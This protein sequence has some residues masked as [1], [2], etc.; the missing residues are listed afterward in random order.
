MTKNP[1][2]PI[3]ILTL[4]FVLALT[5][6]AM[7]QEIK[8]G[9]AGSL[10]GDKASYGISSLR[11][12]EYIADL[13]NAQGGLPKIGTIRVIPADEQCDPALAPAAA[14]R[15]VDDGVRLVMGHICSG[16]TWAALDIYNEADA[17]VIS[18]SATNPPLTQ[19]RK[20]PNFFRTIS[21]DDAQAR[22]EVDFAKKNGWMKLAVLHDGG[23]YGKGLAE[24][25]QQFVMA[26]KEMELVSFMAVPEGIPDYANVARI[27]G[28]SG[29]QA[30]IYGGYHPEAAR[31][32]TALRK[33]RV[34]IP[35]ISDD[36][37]KDETFVRTAGT[38]AEGVYATAPLDVSRHPLAIEAVRAHKLKYGD[39]P[40]AFYLTGAAASRA[41]L[42]AVN[43]AG[44]DRNLSKMAE[45]LRGEWV[46]TELGPIKF[47]ARGDAI[48]VGFAVYQVREGRYVEWK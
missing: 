46:D 2:R 16:A 35:F 15:L 10:T 37:V 5:G 6:P 20:Y 48:G 47:D 34:T 26:D 43:L 11:G 28:R 31:L 14:K 25:V 8:L 13:F 21:S 38:F 41:M 4:L 1:W 32:I 18:P 40:G 30:L 39:D 17:L 33:A 36:G 9:V 45:M 24:F 19:S 29:A 7:A 22:L 3:P 23:S 27:V 12:A 42:N 44:G